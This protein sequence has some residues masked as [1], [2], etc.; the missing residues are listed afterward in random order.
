M[1]EKMQMSD[2]S[3]GDK[4]MLGQA[5]EFNPTASVASSFYLPEAS[6]TDRSYRDDNKNDV[7]KGSYSQR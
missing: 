4:Q 7:L 1:S 3:S 2:G 6:Q 5:E